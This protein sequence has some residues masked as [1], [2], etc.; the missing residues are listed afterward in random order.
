MIKRSIKSYTDKNVELA[1]EVISDD[2]YV[3]SKYLEIINALASKKMVTHIISSLLS[4][5]L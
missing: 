4:I 5:Q 1:N 3:D 2:D